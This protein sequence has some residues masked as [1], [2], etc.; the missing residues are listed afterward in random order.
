MYVFRLRIMNWYSEDP[1]QLF[2]WPLYWPVETYVNT[3]PDFPHLCTSLA[4]TEPEAS[5][6]LGNARSRKT[7]RFV[8]PR[9]TDVHG[10]P[11]PPPMRGRSRELRPRPSRS[12]DS[13]DPPAAEEQGALPPRS[14]LPF[15]G[16]QGASPPPMEERSRELRHRPRPSLS[17]ASKEPLAAHGDGGEEQGA[18]LPP[19]SLALAG[20]QETPRCHYQPLHE[21]HSDGAL[22]CK[23][24]C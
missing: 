22:G 23:H 11:P 10:G 9:K 16:L 5:D 17:S 12:P 7:Y 1:I 15:T 6:L 18:M 19:S 2:G 8:S 4:N 20:L 24:P 21:H 13:K 3:E 14:Y